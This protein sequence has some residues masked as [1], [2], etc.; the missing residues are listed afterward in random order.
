LSPDADATAIA[1][2]AKHELPA[3]VGFG[4]RQLCWQ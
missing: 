3:P 4:L 1:F 2:R